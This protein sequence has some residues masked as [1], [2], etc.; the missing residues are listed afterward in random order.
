MIMPVDEEFVLDS[1]EKKRK[2]KKQRTPIR[3][4][5][6]VHDE[7]E[8]QVESGDEIPLQLVQHHDYVMDDE[9]QHDVQNENTDD[10]GTIQEDEVIPPEDETV[11]D[12][13]ETTPNE[14]SGE[15]E[16][17]E[18]VPERRQ[19]RPRRVFTYDVPGERSIY[20][21]SATQPTYRNTGQSVFDE[22][23]L[24]V[25]FSLPSN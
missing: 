17:V 24:C 13:N 23:Q 20:A 6:P 15:K 22:F 4:Q 25:Q 1:P 8:H 7:G 11:Q 10:D 18:Q 19:R 5:V 21:M 12:E 3:R 16:Q 14:S 2:A 9:T